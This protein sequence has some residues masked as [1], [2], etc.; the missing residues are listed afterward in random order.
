M[1]GLGVEGRGGFLKG[2][3]GD[4]I[5]NVKYNSCSFCDPYC[6]CH[7]MRTFALC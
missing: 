6:I 2:G 5:F 3:G 1:T 7:C 4:N